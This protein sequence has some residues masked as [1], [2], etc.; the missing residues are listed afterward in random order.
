MLVT[1]HKNEGG[2]RGKEKWQ[3]FEQGFASSNESCVPVNI[4]S[5]KAERKQNSL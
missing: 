2:F 4:S 5:E 3:D 1:G